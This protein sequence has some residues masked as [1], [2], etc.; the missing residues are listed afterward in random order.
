LTG[1]VL[2]LAGCSTPMPPDGRPSASASSPATP[3]AI[4]STAPN[5]AAKDEPTRARNAPS[6]APAPAVTDV[7]PGNANANTDAAALQARCVAWAQAFRPEARAAGI[8]E[9]VLDAAFDGLQCQARVVSLDRSQPEFTRPV[10]A[11]LDSAVSP[12]R[13]A[14]GLARLGEP[15]V[16]T[17]LDAASRQD[18][19][20]VPVLAA[21]WGL[22]SDFGRDAGRIPVIDALVTLGA[23]GRRETLARRELLAALR[24]LQAGD[25]DRTH[26]VGSWAGAMGQTQFMPSVFLTDAVDADG[27]GRRDLWQSLPDVMASTARY[28]ARRGWRGDEPWGQEVLLPEGFDAGRADPAN[29]ALARSTADW[30]AEG[31]KAADPQA[32]GLLPMAQAW[33]MLPAGRSGPAFLVGQNWRVI[34]RYN[35]SDSY[36]LAVGLL[37][38]RLAGRNEGVRGAWP[39][40]QAPLSRTQVQA[41]QQALAAQGFQPGPAD[42]V[43]GS[44]TRAALRAWQRREGLP[45]DGYLTPA[46]WQRIVGPRAEVATPP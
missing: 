39:R 30:A 33:V 35:A 10:W 17:A 46:L 23:D 14:R 13:V 15:A 41:L 20:P 36:A 5:P 44:A 29:P 7:P 8:R 40:D 38:D 37:S 34:L 42:G 19:I 18:G 43:P 45:A 9:D 12:A 3:S 4:A 32:G 11:Y 1:A 24:I 31:L 28:L 26:L 21:F 16:R 2:V 6:S 25:A 27:D 22:E